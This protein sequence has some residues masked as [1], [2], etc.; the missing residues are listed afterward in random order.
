VGRARVQEAFESDVQTA[1]QQC[2]KLYDAYGWEEFP[3][4]VKSIL[5]N[6][7]FNLGYGNLQKFRRMNN[8]LMLNNW[9]KAAVEGRD[10]RWYNQ[11]T[12]RAERLMRRLELVGE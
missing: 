2:A 12:N 10:S 11:V 6:M 4:E 8:A 3:G 9:E 5:V 7:I 1:M